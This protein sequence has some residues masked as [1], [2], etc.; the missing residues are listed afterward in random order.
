MKETMGQVIR[1][2]RKGH[3]ITQEELADALGVTAQAVSKWEN[4]VGIPDVSLFVPLANL[5]DVSIDA[6][7]SRKGKSTDVQVSNFL[8]ELEQKNLGEIKKFEILSEALREYP[9]HQDLVKS[10]VRTAF[11]IVSSNNS[12]EGHDVLIKAIKAADSFIKHCDEPGQVLMMKAEKI[13]LLS[14]AGC[15]SEA[16][17]LAR[18]FDDSV[19]AEKKWLLARIFRE[20]KDFSEEIHQRQENIAYLLSFLSGEISELGI[21][22]EMNGSMEEALHVHSLNLKLPYLIHGNESF[23]APLQNSH[24]I[25]G[26]NAAYCLVQLERY[27]EAV[28]VLEK[29]FDYAK[30]QCECTRDHVPLVSP[31]L[32]GIDMEPFHGEMWEEDYLHRIEYEEFAPLWDNPRFQRLLRRFNEY[33]KVNS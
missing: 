20:K 17:I 5:F 8:E 30:I 29:I 3:D 26:F 1:R 9:N 10:I 33:Q 2:L 16:E 27:E 31:L 28:D 22:Y 24:F 23:H 18:E 6:L 32:S 21:A 11:L 13:D 12:G 7:F 14:H 19:Y 4:D 25:S 15:Y